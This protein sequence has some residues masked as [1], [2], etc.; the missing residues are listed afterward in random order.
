MSFDS[1][2]RAVLAGV[3]LAL[4][5]AL[6]A[7]VLLTPVPAQ[8]KLFDLYLQAQLGAGGGGGTGGAQEDNAFASDASGGAYG[9]I[10]G[11]EI[12][13]FD[14]WVNHTQYFGTGGIHGTFTQFMAGFDVD[15]ALDEPDPGKRNEFFAEV[16]LGVGFG[17]GTGRQVDPPLD[18]AQV[19]DK[20]AILEAHVSGE[21]RIN[22]ALSAGVSV[23]IQWA[24]M[25]KNGE[26]VVA[27]DAE[28]HYQQL[29]VAVFAYFQFHVEL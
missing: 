25:V 19:S 2:R 14:V 27:N 6:G 16:G 18:N 22:R 28:N 15:F 5:L 20:G 13:F 11:A 3:R 4:P 8:A 12:L 17:L 9:L 7:T 21:Y 23:P 10:A 1:S 24:Y 29:A 26:G